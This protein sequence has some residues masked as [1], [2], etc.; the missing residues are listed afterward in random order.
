MTTDRTDLM[1]AIDQP[2]IYDFEYFYSEVVGAGRANEGLRTDWQA[3]LKLVQ[4]AC[5]FKYVRF[6]GLYHDDMH[7]LSE[8]DGK[9]VY[10][11]QYIDALFDTMLD[12]GVRPFVEFGFCPSLIATQRDTV[13][14]NLLSP[15]S[16]HCAVE[17]LTDRN[18][19]FSGG[20]V[21]VALLKIWT[22]G[23]IWCGRQ[24]IIGFNAMVC[25][26]F[27]LGISNVGT[28][29][30]HWVGRLGSAR[31]ESKLTHSKPN[32]SAFF[33]GSRS[34][35]YALY[36]CTVKA[37]KQLNAD[38]R[39]GGPATS[40]YVPDT[41]FDDEWE[42]M[43]VQKQLANVSLPSQRG[44][45]ARLTLPNRSKT[46]MPCIGVRFGSSTFS[47]GVTPASSP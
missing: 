24:W 30:V 12:M 13:G 25:T 17:S 46:S 32:L 35:Y 9:H 23:P 3:H 29:S 10:N 33:K 11:F 44:R 45:K 7:V 43:E 34:Q 19:R 41:R 16:V 18:C 31:V 22:N 40:N 42:D 28:R 5:G 37:V 2:K 15:S 47:A 26:R 4:S 6:H 14:P 36:E 21:T 27:A 1:V 8:V 20:K 38:L 39:V